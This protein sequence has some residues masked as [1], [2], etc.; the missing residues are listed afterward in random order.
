VA[1]SESDV[2]WMLDV[3]AEQS[4]EP[5]VAGGWGV[6]ALVGHRTRAHRD[7]DVL[8]PAPFVDAVI[9]AFGNHGFVPAVDW[10]PIRVELSQVDR[11]RHVDIHPA[12]DDLAGG[13]W[14]R[15]FAGE[16]FTSPV[17]ALTVGVIRGRMVRCLTV[18]KQIE[19]HQGYELEPAG[20]HDVEILRRLAP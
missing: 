16:R 8:V 11:D 10:L 17:D 14:Q 15:G 9:A 7:L 13:W 1:T 5:I 12:I 18:Q 2:L 3:M 4:V 6:D 20:L 19:L